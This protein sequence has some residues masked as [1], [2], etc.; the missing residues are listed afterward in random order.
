MNYTKKEVFTIPN[1]LSMLRILLIPLYA[2]LYMKAQSTKEYIA[3]ACVF[4]FSALTD[5]ADGMIARRLNM[6]SRLGIMLD[7]FAD[8]LTQGVIILCLTIKNTAVLPLLVIFIIKEAFMLIMGC[9]LL[10]RGK[11]LDGA[12]LAGKTCT[13]VIFIS[14]AALVVLRDLTP[15]ALYLVIGI[16]GVFMLFSLF[17]YAKCF[18]LPSTHV[19]DIE[20]KNEASE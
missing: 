8:K 4:V 12:L 6:R 13:V 10:S 20:E 17:S 9:R 1:A 2:F 3:S 16:C 19:R 14:M 11:M 7:P 5:M 18:F 15:L